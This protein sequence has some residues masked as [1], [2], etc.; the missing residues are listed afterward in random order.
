MNRV[1]TISF[2]ANEVLTILKSLAL[3]KTIAVYSFLLFFLSK[4]LTVLTKYNIIL[5]RKKTI[6]KKFLPKNANR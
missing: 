2:S 1:L 5:Y 4:V 3:L 6:K